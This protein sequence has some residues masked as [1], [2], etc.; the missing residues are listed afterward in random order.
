MAYSI[1]STSTFDNN[2][3]SGNGPFT[4]AH[5]CA[6]GAQLYCMVS[7]AIAASGAGNITGVTYNGI[8]MTQVTSYV[9]PG[10]TVFAYIFFLDTPASGTH[11]VV[12]STSGNTYVAVDNISFNGANGYGTP[13]T[14]ATDTISV[15]TQF[16]NDYII[17]SAAT[18][19]ITTFQTLTPVD[20]QTMLSNVNLANNLAGGASYKLTTLPGA[21][22]LSYNTANHIMSLTEV[23]VISLE[24]STFV[25]QMIIF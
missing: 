3:N 19:D 14:S 9:A 4:V 24:A 12:V 11:N 13:S 21:Y 2:H 8:A 15:T 18:N 1:D 22:G 5:T 20:S 23:E 7:G 17:G 16:A 10:S 25:P 6:V